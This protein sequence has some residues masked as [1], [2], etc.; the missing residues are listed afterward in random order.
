M[1]KSSTGTRNVESG[2]TWEGWG[3]R[4]RPGERGFR[5]ISIAGINDV[6]A[7]WGSSL[8]AKDP[9]HPS[10]AGGAVHALD[11]NSECNTHTYC[12]STSPPPHP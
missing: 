10:A 1:G 3:R 12:T 11:F 8:P 4:Q 6:L 2:A 5:R 9:H 7:A